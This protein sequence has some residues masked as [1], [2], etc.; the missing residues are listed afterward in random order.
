MD[1]EQE[2]M[3]NKIILTL[4]VTASIVWIGY[5]GLDILNSKHNFTPNTLFSSED[6]SVL[7]INRFNEISIEQVE[8]FEEA[9]LK[10][11][12]TQL[13]TDNFSTLY[14][15]Q[16]LPHLYV[17]GHENWDEK[18]IK[19]LFQAISNDLKI[20]SNTF[21]VGEY[22]GRYFKSKL[23]LKKGEIT[24]N[25]SD[26]EFSYDKKA[27]ASIITFKENSE[28][29]S[30]TDI[31]H[32]QNGKV[33]FITR[34]AQIEQGNQVK[35]EVIF[36]R[37]ISSKIKSYHFYE[38]DYYATM[39]DVFKNGPMNSWCLNGFV[40]VNYGG[41]RAFIADYIVGQDP[42]LILNELTQST[43]EATFKTP[44]TND[45]PKSGT[46][47]VKYL[48]DLVVISENENTC[49]NLIADFK[50]GNTIALNSTI[51]HSFF[52]DL[53]KS[54]SERFISKDNRYSKA[55]YNGK[56]LETTFGESE[57]L[58]MNKKSETLA[59]NCGFDVKD[60]LV[61]ENATSIIALGTKGEVSYFEGGKLMWKKAL[62]TS[63]V[64]EIQSIDL[65]ESSEEY[66]LLNTSSHIHLWNKK[67]E[68]VSGFPIEL[69][70][71]ATNDVKFYRWSGKSYFM[72]GNDKQQVVHYDAKGRELNVI[73]TAIN[74]TR[75]IDVWVS[76]QQ[77]YAG[78]SDGK[79]FYMY[80][81]DRSRQHRE[82][83]IPS[84]SIAV[85]I[86]NELVQFGIEDG[87][88]VR[89]DQ[90]GIAAKLF[91]VNNGK[92][93]SYDQNGK[94]PYIVVKSAN[95]LELINQQGISFGKIT[96]PFNEIEHVFIENSVSGNNLVSIIDG[97]EN[98]VYLY[99]TNG[100]K[101]NN[102][103]FEGQQKAV[104]SS[105]KTSKSITTIVDQFIVQYYLN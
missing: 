10:E 70:H 102:L 57:Q 62:N 7:I 51:Q 87:A 33:E 94:N 81:L 11:L 64:F 20:E 89:I 65:H 67:G 29:L 42:I 46:Y 52:G 28:V 25:T 69:E 23:Y 53:P 83:R 48:D 37:V 3:I 90:K 49:D 32:Q 75:K 50:L 44:L 36:A 60:F 55:I 78:F 96:V 12:V 40:S 68:A 9:P 85:K 5:V 103:M 2:T 6:G 84:N 72:I 91:A 24:A 80:H 43:N 15:S 26:A 61:L 35:D 73:K 31:Y 86:P 76:L 82:F 100:E 17:Q 59:M 79:S 92:I 13:P 45:F 4:I 58:E 88:L 1:L 101:V 98:N 99:R 63:D 14:I 77:L 41:E 74:V 21:T 18:T 19:A 105:T 34:N 8:Q 30:I 97:I 66:L 38:R 54:V 104:I 39:D 95:E 56:I 93:L 27:S 22:S 47:F 71:D 16:K